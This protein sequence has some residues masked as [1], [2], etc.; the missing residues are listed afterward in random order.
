MSQKKATIAGGASLLGLAGLICKIIGVLYRI[1]LAHIIG[2]TG[3][4]IYQQVFPLYNLLLCISSAGIPVAISRMVSAHLAK[5]DPTNARKVFHVSL[6][7][8]TAF[9]FVATLFLILIRDPLSVA[10]GT[11]EASFGLVM[12]APSIFLVCVMSAYRGQFQGRQHM[13]PT[14]VS[15]LIEQLGKVFLAIP[16]SFVFASYGKDAFAHAVLGASGA[17]FG[18]SLGEAAAL[19]YMWAKYALTKKQYR[20]LSQDAS[21]AEM[22][23]KQLGKQVMIT[24]LPITIGAVIVPICASVDSFM[25]VNIMDSYYQQ[26]EALIRYGLYTGL[27]FPLINVPTAF[28]MAMSVSLVPAISR[29]VAKK[30]G[31]NIKRHTE[32]GLRLSTLIALPASFGLSL[33][34]KPVLSVLYGASYSAEHIALSASLLQISSLTIFFFTLVQSTSGILQGLSKQ[35]IP[36]YTLIV[37]V[38]LKIALN[39]A[40]V[41]QSSINI[42][43][44]PYA[45]LLCYGVSLFLNLIYVHKHT[46]L[47]FSLKP[48]LSPLLPTLLMSAFLVMV[49]LWF[50]P[51]V[52][53]S[54]LVLMFVILVSIVIFLFASLQ[55][56]AIQKSDLPRKLQ[57]FARK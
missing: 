14:A 22:P 40:L 2:P 39:Y 12:I 4:G 30:D 10:L 49:M 48:Y 33:L 47:R 36:M 56:G 16:F 43:G 1:P 23:Y 27:V 57:R 44:A 8:L 38:V 19:L 7:L 20:T 51:L 17:L 52:C 54:L 3:M 53:S 29:A 25:L 46:K 50:E 15:Q 32:T 55:L 11:P 42:H 28:A 6:W 45:S 18:T 13:T 37:G 24:A 34:A 35:R 21:Q 41:S 26:G 9:G 5:N 31:D